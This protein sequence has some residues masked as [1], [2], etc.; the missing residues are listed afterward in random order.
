MEDKAILKK[1]RE[2]ELLYKKK[3]YRWQIFYDVGVPSGIDDTTDDI[4]ADEEFTRVKNINFNMSG[5][6]AIAKLKLT[7]LV[8]SVNDLS[9]YAKFAKVL[10]PEE[11]IPLYEAGRW[12]SDVE[13]GRQVLNGVNPMVIKK[14]TTIPA[15]FPVTEDMVKPYLARG[16]SLKEELEVSL[17]LIDSIYTTQDSGRSHSWKT[18]GYDVLAKAQY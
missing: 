3:K 18:Y 7:G 5:L 12:T 6:E 15:K 11:A 16:L 14:C 8:T 17:N 2:L 1:Q 4:P 13:F 9:D 10:N